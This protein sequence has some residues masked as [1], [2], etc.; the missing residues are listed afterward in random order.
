LFSAGQN[1]L[2][3]WS[4]QILCFPWNAIQVY[5]MSIKALFF[6]GYANGSF[7]SLM[8][9][10]SDDRITLTKWLIVLLFKIRQQNPIH[11]LNLFHRHIMKSI[12]LV[13]VY[14]F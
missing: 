10:N 1:T 2:S 14:S 12:M 5:K 8:Q 9:W 4:R 7:F 13:E 11:Y 3:S 6:H